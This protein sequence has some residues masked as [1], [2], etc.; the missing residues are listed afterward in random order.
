MI[1][2]LP[3]ATTSSRGSATLPFFGVKPV[4]LDAEG[5]IIDGEPAAATW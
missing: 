3:G 2:P 4:L 1:S 5:H